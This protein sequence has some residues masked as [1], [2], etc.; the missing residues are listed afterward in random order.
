MKKRLSILLLFISTCLFSQYTETINS[1]RPG[2]S[3]GAFSVGRDV[4]QFEIGGNN[5]SFS[6]ANLNDSEIR[7][8]NA[9]YN[10]RYGL[11]FE[12]LEIFLKGSYNTRDI[13]DN[14]KYNT[15]QKENFLAE[16]SLGLKYLIFDPF[17]NKKWHSVDLYSWRSNKKIKLTDLIPAV[18]IFAGGDYLFENNVQY[19]DQFFYLKKEN[20]G[21]QDQN[22]ILP[23]IGI[24][25]QNH[26][27]GKWVIV[28][29]LSLENFGSGYNKIN[30]IF[31]LT[32]NLSNPRW[33]I[34]A[35]YQIIENDIYSDNFFKFGIANLVSK[36][37][38]V[39][40]NFGGSLKNTPSNSYVDF[41]FSKRLDWHRDK[42]P[43][44]RKKL[45][46]LRDKLKQEKR[47]EK[48][49]KKDSKKVGKQ[50]KKQSRQEKKQIKK[51]NKPQRKK[52][53][54]F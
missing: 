52:F 24:A 15:S 38:Q 16:H 46:E 47:A 12:N 33:S 20:F 22:T 49:N 53:L 18:S 19:D 28:N 42:L 26:F 21:Y 29:N 39:D 51:A 25:T 44:D 30:Y 37:L 23:F 11:Y 32:H 6:H 34:F 14:Y 13:I 4:L 17:K 5:Y 50:N 43:I 3:H 36:N 45:K 10:I 8:I 40:L 48:S 27:L 54:I 7:G 1:N 2:T 35:E 31:T 9:V 41:G